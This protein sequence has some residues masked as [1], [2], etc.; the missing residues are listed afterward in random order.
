[1]SVSSQGHLGLVSKSTDLFCFT[2]DFKKFMAQT[3]LHPKSQIH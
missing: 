3:P 1:M 2:H